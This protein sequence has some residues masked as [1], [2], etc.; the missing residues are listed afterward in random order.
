LF[1]HDVVYCSTVT[2]NAIVS[3]LF[4]EAVKKQ[5]MDTDA[6]EQLS[7]E[8]LP[9][10]KLKTFLQNGSNCHN[11]IDNEGGGSN[12][13]VVKN[14]KQIAELFP[15]TTIMFADIAGFTAWASSREP[16]H[17]FTLLETL[18]GAF[19]SQARRMGEFG[20]FVWCMPRHCYFFF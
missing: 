6:K 1:I 12:I 11:V 10:G 2:S 4:P 5:L 13:F 20:D 14:T 15:E 8:T 3:S 7:D 19:D 9:K 17:V 16:S 18:Y